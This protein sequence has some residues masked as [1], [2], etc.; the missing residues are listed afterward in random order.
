MKGKN[1]LII[2]IAVVFI[3][4]LAIVL[5]IPKESFINRESNNKVISGKDNQNLEDKYDTVEILNENII[6]PDEKSEKFANGED[7]N[8]ELNGSL[9]SDYI[10]SLDKQY[11][12]IQQNE[13]IVKI[14]KDIEN[15][16]EN[17]FYYQNGYTYIQ[18]SNK[19][20]H[21]VNYVLDP[22]KEEDDSVTIS[23]DVIIGNETEELTDSY[24]IF[25]LPTSKEIRFVKNGGDNLE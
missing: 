13:S 22:I 23:Y 15:K 18:I 14:V 12:D 1:K 25:R 24:L 10:I 17:S 3:T 5:L 4:V 21:I 7:I 9:I 8:E 16:K 2:L 11:F 20:N 19:T 6:N